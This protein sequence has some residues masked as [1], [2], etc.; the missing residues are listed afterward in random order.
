M[1]RR[2]CGVLVLALACAPGVREPA[3]PG[4]PE[5]GSTVRAGSER[6]AAAPGAGAA[7]PAGPGV[8]PEPREATELPAGLVQPWQR[9]EPGWL[10]EASV[11]VVADYAG[12]QAQCVKESGSF[13]M[14]A[15]DPGF[16]P[17]RVLRGAIA[18]GRIPIDAPRGP[19]YP[20]ALVDGRSY[21]LLLRPGPTNA[22]RLADARAS[23]EFGER[24]AA[25]EVV[26]IVDLSQSAGE[27]ALPVPASRS[28]APDR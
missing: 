4:G 3:P 10:A 26:A 20:P 5:V 18:A 16:T 11:W 9:V 1:L 27:A 25:E 28:G 2:G 12:M 19:S 17:T 7:L 13:A 15:S 8:A 24:L 14:V 23:F 6:G 22:R 21:L